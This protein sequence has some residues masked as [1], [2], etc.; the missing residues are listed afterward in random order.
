[1]SAAARTTGGRG[2]AAAV[3]LALV[4]AA[5]VAGQDVRLA[6]RPRTD[7]Q[8]ALETF[9]HRSLDEADP[10]RVITL[11]T[12]PGVEVLRTRRGEDFEEHAHED[13]R[14]DDAH[15]HTRGDPHIW[16]DAG[17]ALKRL[18]D[19]VVRKQADVFRCNRVDH[20][21]SRAFDRGRGIQ[22]AANT[23]NRDF[24]E[25]FVVRRRCLV[26]LRHGRHRRESRDQQSSRGQ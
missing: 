11:M 8:E 15:R 7:G 13:H 2:L 9:L 3:T 10:R 18:G 19:V 6:D 25:R 23:N 1:M 16:L 21:V 20:L 26:C 12:L 4:G 22:A 24:L 14:I 17:N 5:G